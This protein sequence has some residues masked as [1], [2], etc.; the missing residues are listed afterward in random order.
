M[1]SPLVPRKKSSKFS[2]HT[3]S[4]LTL[5]SWGSATVLSVEILSGSASLFNKMIINH[6]NKAPKPKEEQP[7]LAVLP[8]E[9]SESAYYN[10]ICE[11]VE[12][13]GRSTQ[14]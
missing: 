2:S 7:K 6:K 5:P 14:D 12:S 13:F 9:E 3:H 11:F 10:R 4:K 1:Q 8:I